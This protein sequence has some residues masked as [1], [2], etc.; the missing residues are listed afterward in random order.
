MHEYK[1]TDDFERRS[2]VV[3][4][5]ALCRIRK[6]GGPGPRN[7]EQFGAPV[8]TE[9]SEYFEEVDDDMDE[10][11]ERTLGSDVPVTLKPD[12]LK[13]PKEETLSDT[14]VPDESR[15]DFHKFL[16]DLLAEN[17]D[18]SNNSVAL[19]MEKDK[20]HSHSPV[21]N[22]QLG[23]CYSDCTTSQDALAPD[24]QNLHWPEAEDVH[25]LHPTYDEEYILG[26]LYFLTD[27]SGSCANQPEYSDEEVSPN[28]FIH[29][30]SR[31]FFDSIESFGG[32]NNLPCNFNDYLEMNDIET[33]L[34]EIVLRSPRLF[35]KEQHTLLSSANANQYEASQRL[36]LKV[37]LPKNANGMIT[38]QHGAISKVIS[39]ASESGSLDVQVDSMI[40]GDGASGCTEMQPH[41]SHADMCTSAYPIPRTT[42]Y[43]SQNRVLPSTSNSVSFVPSLLRSASGIMKEENRDCEAAT[44]GSYIS[45]PYMQG[46]CLQESGLNSQATSDSRGPNNTHELLKDEKDKEIGHLVSKLKTLALGGSLSEFEHTLSNPFNGK[47]YALG[48]PISQLLHLKDYV[49]PYT[50]LRSRTVA[51]FCHLGLTVLFLVFIFLGLLHILT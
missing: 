50:S 37:T 19:N 13:A 41:H 42:D 3:S 11:G 23:H 33:P 35:S 34:D 38:E 48:K 39:K 26:E 6:K 17:S 9:G 49:N 1:L 12:G 8:Y 4:S 20:A 18:V 15:D 44:L 14:V 5:V 43:I 21:C 30:D 16:E 2:K 10:K 24:I 28:P 25:V 46:E 45:S 22:S 40:D 36:R 32:L 51:F 7:G 31:Q 47:V 27:K 29:M